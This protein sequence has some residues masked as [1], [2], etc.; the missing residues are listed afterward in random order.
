MIDKDPDNDEYKFVESDFQESSS[1]DNRLEDSENASTS[2]AFSSNQTNNIRRNALITIGLIFLVFFLYLFFS[3]N[4]PKIEQSSLPPATQIATQ[5]LVT[6]N[7]NIAPQPVAN[8]VDPDLKQ[9][10]ATIETS[11]QS[12]SAQVAS[13]GQQIDTISTNVN[14]LNTEI[15]KLNQT[16][17]TLS[18]Q[19]E[20]QSSEV[21][22]IMSR[23]KVKPA[24]VHVMPGPPPVVYFIKAIIPGR[25]WLIG[26][27]GSTLSVRE[28]LKLYGY[29]TIKL[30]DSLQSRVVT[31]SGK[32]I[33][34]SQDDS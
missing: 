25:A 15:S 29:G 27:D 26:S 3:R 19:V 18:S 34:F 28:G 31:S 21:Q 14:N 6:A 13:M 17:T 23:A 11:Q 33:R 7:S 30:I 10:V 16:I 32:I 24:K 4:K 1:L 20:K 5:P 2:H 22:V 8:Q 12:F 9:K